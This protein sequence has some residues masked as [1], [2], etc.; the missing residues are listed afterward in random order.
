MKLKEIYK[1]YHKKP[2]EPKI[3]LQ[4]SIRIPLRISNSVTSLS[5]KKNLIALWILLRDNVQHNDPI[6]QPLKSKDLL[7]DF[8][9][10][11]L[12]Q[13]EEDTAKGFS[14]FVSEKLIESILE[15]NDYIEYKKILEAL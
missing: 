13:W 9:Y 10:N 2:K 15:E 5:L 6:L 14:D 4:Q 1:N 3:Q 12:D 11:C 8:V 7:T